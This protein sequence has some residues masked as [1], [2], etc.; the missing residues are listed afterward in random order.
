[1]LDRLFFLRKIH[2]LKTEKPVQKRPIKIVLLIFLLLMLFIIHN[3][4][5]VP[6]EAQE[7]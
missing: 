5:Q 4:R 7:R 6:P 2:F 3:V 1:M